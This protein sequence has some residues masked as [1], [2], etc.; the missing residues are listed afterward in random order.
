MVYLSNPCVFTLP[1]L[2]TNTENS[3]GIEIGARRTFPAE[4]FIMH[5]ISLSGLPCPFLWMM[6]STYITRNG[7]YLPTYL[8]NNMLFVTSWWFIQ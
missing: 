6:K 8:P 5:T 7:T 3:K 1:Y 2:H 4:L